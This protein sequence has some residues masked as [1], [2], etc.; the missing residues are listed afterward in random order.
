M[1]IEKV[2]SVAEIASALAVVIT[3]II[4]IV[5]VRENTETIRL[6]AYQSSIDR[7]SSWRE[8]VS[9]DYQK[10]DL[11]RRFN[12]GEVPARGTTESTI[13]LMV[14]TTLT[15][16]YESAYFAYENELMGEQEWARIENSACAAMGPIRNSSFEEDI[17]FR[18]TEEYKSYLQS[19][20]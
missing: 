19:T 17:Y 5:N 8:E 11:F 18:L 3:L 10:A 15:N 4:L 7:F 20:C 6:A 12:Q 9:S 13:L 1:N 16:N 2:A 14:L